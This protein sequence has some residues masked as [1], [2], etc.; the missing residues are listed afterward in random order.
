MEYTVTNEK[1]QVL[2][3]I[4]VLDFV[5]EEYIQ[6]IDGGR[7]SC[8]CTLCGKDFIQKSDAKR[9]I[10]AKHSGIE[11]H[12]SCN[13]CGKTFKNQQTVKSHMRQTHGHYSKHN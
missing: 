10:M 1:K 4:F 9:H 2:I 13:I 11:Q 5:A 7:T 12:V 3:F 6:K 8:A